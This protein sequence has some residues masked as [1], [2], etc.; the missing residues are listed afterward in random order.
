MPLIEGIKLC[1]WFGRV[2]ALKDVDITI[3]RGKVVGLVGDNGAG[4]STLIKI[5][6]GVHRPDSGELWFE[7]KKVELDAVS[8]THLDVYKRQTFGS[9]INSFPVS[10]CQ[11]LAYDVFPLAAVI[12]IRSVY[13]VYA[14][15]YGISYHADSFFS[16]GPGV[17]GFR[18]GQPHTAKP[19]S[20][21]IKAC[22]SQFSIL[23]SNPSISKV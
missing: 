11:S 5:L 3:E 10:V 16:I 22:L 19:Q 12:V 18:A 1:K 15:I 8:Y 7:G 9:K 23:H 20:G 14:V 21:N 2:A 6:S 4:K 17:A 13:V